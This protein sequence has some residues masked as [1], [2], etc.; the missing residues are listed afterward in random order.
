MRQVLD[1]ARSNGTLVFITLHH[2]WR[3]V[4]DVDVTPPR[5]LS[6]GAFDRSIEVPFRRRVH[7][8]PTTPTIMSSITSREIGYSGTQ[9]Q[10]RR[11]VEPCCAPPSCT[12]RRTP[13]CRRAASASGCSTT[14]SGLPSS[15]RTCASVRRRSRCWN[16]SVR[17]TKAVASSAP[18]DSVAARSAVPD[19]RPRTCGPRQFKRHWSK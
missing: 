5:T 2:H 19:R 1:A 15:S 13:A 12:R 11:E 7:W 17:I 14:I 3:K 4:V 8:R 16:T 6:F 10:S 18:S 9:E